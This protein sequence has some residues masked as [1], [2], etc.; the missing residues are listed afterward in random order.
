MY[1]R[2]LTEARILMDYLRHWFVPDLY[3][4]GIFQDHFVK[5]TGWLS[6]VTTLLSMIVHVVTISAAFVYRR[7]LPLL[8]LAVLFFYA[9][10]VLESTLIKLELYYEHRNYLATVFL[11]L[12]VAALLFEKLDRRAFALSG[13]VIAL[14]LTGFTRYSATLWSSYPTMLTAA[15]QKAPTSV[16]AQTRYATFLFDKAEYQASLEVIDRAIGTIPGNHADLLLNRLYMLC[17]LNI[18]DQQ[19]FEKTAPLLSTMRFQPG[20]FR[21][22]YLFVAG[23]ADGHCPGLPVEALRS[24]FVGQLEVP[25]NRDPDSMRYSQLHYLLGYIDIAV[26]EPERAE[27]LFDETLRVE[28]RADTALRMAKDFAA[29]AYLDRALDFSERALGL[30][31]VEGTAVGVGEADI[32]AFRNAVQARLAELPADDNID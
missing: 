18:L 16:R 30:M 17:R 20:L 14:L 19:E 22:Y 4:A 13:I 6:P 25:L 9:S 11:I 8:A 32:V 21:L 29:R 23:V 28:P 5:S 26:G 27:S 10:H 1:E 3:T 2:V 15:A 31:S 24:T 7:K 12:P